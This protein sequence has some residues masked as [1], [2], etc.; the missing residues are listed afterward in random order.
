MALRA[1]PGFDAVLKAVLGAVGERSERLLYL[2][3][4]VRVSARQYP[5]LHVMVTECATALDLPRVPGA[6]FDKSRK[7]TAFR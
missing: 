3:T 2:A 5:E 4:A 7:L 1:V 6:Q